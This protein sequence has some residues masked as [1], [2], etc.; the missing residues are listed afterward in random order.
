MSEWMSID[1]WAECRT[2]ERPGIIFEVRNAVG[3]T[4]L[5]RC[6]P[7]PLRSFDWT[8]GPTQFRAVP[9]P[10]PRRSGPIPPPRETR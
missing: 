2:M 3:Q 1:R 9:D 4:M 8:S 6:T 5:T 7:T 10:G